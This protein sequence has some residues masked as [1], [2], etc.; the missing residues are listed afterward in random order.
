MFNRILR[1]LQGCLCRA[2]DC[3]HA[4]RVIFAIGPVG[5]Q[6]RPVVKTP[7]RCRRLKTQEIDMATQLT[8]TQFTTIRVRAFKDK[9]G[10]PAAVDGPPQWNTSN[11]D[12]LA[13]EPADDGMSCKVSAVGPIGTAL[14]QMT[15]DVKLGTDFE[16][17]IGTVDFEV[18]PGQAT[19]VELDVDPASEQPE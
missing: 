8:V 12:V 15:A 19:V 9:K 2:L 17:L 11:S 13:I 7:H 18:T 5:E 6:T 1:I 4:G 3:R 10:N 14:V 16:P